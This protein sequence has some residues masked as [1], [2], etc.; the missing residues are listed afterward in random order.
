MK[1]NHLFFGVA[2]A[3]L[4]LVSSCKDNVNRDNIE[5]IFEQQDS[6]MLKADLDPKNFQQEINDKYINLFTLKNDN[7]LEAVFT[8]YGQRLV[9]LYVPDSKGNFDDVVLGFGSLQQYRKAKEKF[10]GATIGRYGNRIANGQFKL[11]DSI[12][13]LAKNNGENHLHGGNK[14]FES[15]VWNAR[16]ISD[17]KLEFT[18]TSPDG[19]EGYPGNLKVKVH[20]EL[21]NENELKINYY[22]TTDKP[23]PVNLTHHSFFNLSGAGN[24]SINNHKLMIN[25]DAFTPIDE[26]LIPTG[27]LKKVTN[28]PFDFRELK[29]IGK[30]LD[31]TANE[32]LRRAKGYDHNFV[33]NN[34]SL[35]SNEI[36]L[37]ARVVEPMSGRTMEVFTNEP[38]LQF[39]G[40]N[41]LNGKTKGKSGKPY[42]F[43]G[44]FCLET[45]HFPDSPNQDNFPSTILKPDEEYRSVCI[46]KFGTLQ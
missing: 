24:G 12:Y 20:Y 25:A 42:D 27:E 4:I 45:Q 2:V 33:L 10:F 9:S 46:Y 11:D 32:Q 34:K 6:V 19:E 41:F 18:R 13:Q 22:A 7:G 37:A 16:Q 26:G 15:V 31:T 3:T 28:T 21:T 30:D 23:T 35:G 39:Y 40:G 5:N 8:N 43:R 14:G 29:S 36:I 44:A 1:Y 17:Y 38:G